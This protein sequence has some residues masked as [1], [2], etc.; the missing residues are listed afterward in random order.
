METLTISSKNGVG[1]DEWLEFLI[2]ARARTFASM[3]SAG[4]P[5]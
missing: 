5:T 1:M 2:S 3:Q 4:S